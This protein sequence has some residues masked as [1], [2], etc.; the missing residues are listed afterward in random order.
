MSHFTV[1]VIGNNPGELLA[2]YDE[3]M[4]VEPYREDIPQK[5]IDHMVEYYTKYAEERERIENLDTNDRTTLTRYWKRFKG[6]EMLIDEDGTPYQMN[7]YNPK[8]KWDWYEEGGRWQGL[9]RLKHGEK[10]VL[11]EASH[12]FENYE[13]GTEYVDS[14][15]MSAIDWQYMRNDPERLLHLK[16]QWEEG[17]RGNNSFYK[18]GY[19]E[20]QYGNEKEFLRRNL[21]FS[22]FAVVTADGEWH[23]VGRMGL[24]ARSSDTPEDE[25]TWL[26]NYWEAFLEGLDPDTQVT[27]YD[28]HI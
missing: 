24:W 22:T 20:E 27:I 3:N 12:M 15:K 23:E 6:G 18:S 1:L 2:P 13:H 11:G 25:K 21:T 7:T 16:L 10:G 19:Y 4:E 8:S 26:D 28:C 5:D 14:A 17:I 9:L